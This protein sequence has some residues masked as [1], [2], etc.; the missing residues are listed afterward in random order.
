ME[1]LDRIPPMKEIP[2]NRVVVHNR[3]RPQP[4]L[5]ENGFRAWLAPLDDP[6]VVPCECDWAPELGRHYRVAGVGR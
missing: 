6:R 2:G 4:Q 5:G 1:Y 3:V